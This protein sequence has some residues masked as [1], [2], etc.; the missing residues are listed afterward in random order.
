MGPARWHGRAAS[1]QP[2]GGGVALQAAADR[3]RRPRA[4]RGRSTVSSSSA[5]GRVSSTTPRSVRGSKSARARSGGTAARGARFVE[6][7]LPSPSCWGIS[8]A[9]RSAGARP[10]LPGRKMRC[11]TSAEGARP[12]ESVRPAN[13][14]LLSRSG[15]PRTVGMLLAGE[16]G[17]PQRA[18]D[19]RREVDRSSRRCDGAPIRRACGSAGSRSRRRRRAACSSEQ[20]GPLARRAAASRRRRA[21]DRQHVQAA[22]W[23]G[24]ATCRRS[25]SRSAGSISRPQRAAL[26]V[27]RRRGRAPRRRPRRDLRADRRNF[28]RLRSG[29][30]WRGRSGSRSGRRTAGPA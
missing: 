27:D 23:S 1:D 21:F 14:C 8:K 11:S 15:L 24:T 4:G 10:P 28:A 12:S 3:R 30:G 17:D 16:Q 22:S 7:D 29:S 20:L 2:V 6:P 5:D 26:I 19:R 18:I 13:A 9:S 25:S